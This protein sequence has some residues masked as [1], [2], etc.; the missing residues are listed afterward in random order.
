MPNLKFLA[1]IVEDMNR[2]FKKNIREKWNG[3]NY[4]PYFAYY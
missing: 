1:A 3:Y 2:F 4:Q